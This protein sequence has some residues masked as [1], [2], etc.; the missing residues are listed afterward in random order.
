[1]IQSFQ[2]K[3]MRMSIVMYLDTGVTLRDATGKKISVFSHLREASKF[4]VLATSTKQIFLALLMVL[5]KIA[6]EH[7]H[8]FN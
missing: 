5:F 1:M 3:D 7:P 2:C 4:L 6:N 8:Y